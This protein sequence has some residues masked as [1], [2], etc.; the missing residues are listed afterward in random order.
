MTTKLQEDSN[1]YNVLKRKV[2]VEI[3]KAEN[4]K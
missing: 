1:E 3:R 2:K 4:R